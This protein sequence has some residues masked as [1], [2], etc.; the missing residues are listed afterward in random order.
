MLAGVYRFLFNN[1]R[2][3]KDIVPKTTTMSV[4]A[5]HMI[6]PKASPETELMSKIPKAALTAMGYRP[7][8][9]LVVDMAKAPATKAT[10]SSLRDRGQGFGHRMFNDPKHAQY[11]QAQIKKGMKNERPFFLHF[12]RH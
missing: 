8:P 7:I 4:C 12:E 2:T 3:M 5:I 9:P 11:K 10:N 6:Q 1:G